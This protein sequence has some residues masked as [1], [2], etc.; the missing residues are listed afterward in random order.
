[1]T[2]PK[3]RELDKVKPECLLPFS[4]HHISSKCFSFILFFYSVAT[5]KV[6][7]YNHYRLCHIRSDISTQDVFTYIHMHMHARM[8]A[9]IYTHTHTTKQNKNTTTYKHACVI[10]FKLQIKGYGLMHLFKILFYALCEMN[11]SGDIGRWFQKGAHLCRAF[12]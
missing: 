7:E 11:E 9:H 1:M 5:F 2:H 3:R 8:Q 4:Y 10:A 6:D 12:T